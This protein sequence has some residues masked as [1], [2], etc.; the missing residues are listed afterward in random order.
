MRLSSTATRG[1]K[2]RTHSSW[3]LDTSTTATSAAA[4][5]RP[6]V[7]ERR[8]EVAAD[9]GRAPVRA[10]ISPSEHGRR[11]LPVG[12]GDR[13]RSGASS[14]S[15]RELDLA[16]HRDA[17]RDAR[18]EHRV[19]RAARRGWARPG[20]RRR[21]LGRGPSPARSSTDAP[22][23]RRSPRRRVGGA[24]DRSPRRATPRAA[25]TRATRRARPR[26]RRCTERA[27]VSRRASVVIA[28]SA[29]RAR[30]ARR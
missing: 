11:A 12:A 26:E 27:R 18:R 5:R 9:E 24:L 8:A 10:S 1:R 29:W 30:A 2:R 19:R 17:A 21:E 22:R 6:R 3:K 14:E 4:R 16:P 13:R 25:S 7:D 28:A 15:R 20:R 23:A